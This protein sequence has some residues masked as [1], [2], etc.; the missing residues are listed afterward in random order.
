MGHVPAMSAATETLPRA[1]RGGGQRGCRV[2]AARGADA[3]RGGAAPL[4]ARAAELLVRRGV[5]AG[6]RPAP[7]PRHDAANAVPNTENTPPLW[8]LLEWFDYRAARHR[9]VRA[10]AALGD[11]RDRA[12]ARRLGIGMRARR[13]RRRD[14]VRRARRRQPAVRLV[15][16]GGARLRAVHVH[17]GA[18]DARFV[19]VLRE[20]SGRRLALF[21]LAGALA[22][23]SHYFAV[24]LLGRNGRCGCS[25]IGAP[26]GRRCRRS[27]ALARGRARAAAADLAQGGHGTQWIGRW[28]LKERIADI[29]RTT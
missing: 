2:V 20:P 29:P 13:P 19:R 28:P 22:L 3:A 11:R 16:A 10:A 26:A 12:R 17:R 15:L 5:H 6:A 21:A 9:R 24:F 7:E 8:Y 27:S 1:A 4:D 25:P 23:L 18:R 14:R